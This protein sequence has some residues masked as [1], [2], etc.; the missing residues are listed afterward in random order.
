[1]WQQMST[2]KVSSSVERCCR[3]G[4]DTASLALEI[5]LALLHQLCDED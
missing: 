3:D 5:A 4:Q 1:M 2:T